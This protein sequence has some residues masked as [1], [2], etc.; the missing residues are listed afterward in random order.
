[1]SEPLENLYFNWL[2]AKVLRVENPTPSLTYWDLLRV[3]YGTEFVW[4]LSGDD[5]R[6]EDGLDLRREFLI[7]GDIPDDLLW[8]GLP[9]SVLEVLVAFARRTEFQTEIP[10]YTWFWEFIENLGLGDCNDAACCRE[11]DIVEVL[12]QFVWRTY[13]LNGQGGIFPIEHPKHDQTKV[14]LWYQFFEYLSD[15]HRLT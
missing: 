10:A 15:Q 8:R 3:L 1:M 4:L 13:K 12:T 5:N 2:C 11:S 14:E 6:V 7:T 9:C